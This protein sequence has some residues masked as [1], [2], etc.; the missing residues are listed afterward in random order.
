MGDSFYHIFTIPY[1]FL[2]TLFFGRRG[3]GIHNVITKIYHMSV[4]TLISRKIC[5]K[6]CYDCLFVILILQLV[7][8]DLSENF[9]KFHTTK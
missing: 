9:S 6:N 2:I 4:I 1:Q 7:D 5:D 8:L 3:V